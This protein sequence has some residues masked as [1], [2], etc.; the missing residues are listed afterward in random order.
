[1]HGDN[2]MIECGQGGHLYG[3][4]PYNLCS[5]KELSLRAQ[6]LLAH[7]IMKIGVISGLYP[8]YTRGGAEW[9]AADEAR[10]L[11]D[12][13][14]DVFVITT[15]PWQGW[16]SF[17]PR[18][19]EE[20]GVRVYR[21]FSLNIFSYYRI[22]QHVFL[23]RALWHLRDMFNLSAA[24]VVKKIV[25]AE[26]PD[27]V[28]THNLKG[29][30]FLVPHALHALSVKHIHTLHDVHLV[31]PSGLLTVGGTEGR[32]ARLYTR[33]TRKLFGSPAVVRAPSEWLL[34]FYGDRG[35]FPNSQ[36]QVTRPAE[37][38]A[39]GAAQ[40]HKERGDCLNV[41]FVGQLQ[42]HK[43]ILFLMNVWKELISE[44][45]EK[46]LH[47]AI[48]GDGLLANQMAVQWEGY[49]SVELHG[50]TTRDRLSRLYKQADVVVVPSL[51]YEN[52]PTVIFEAHS[53][54]VPVIATRAGGI[55]EIVNEHDV[56]VEAGDKDGLKAAIEDFL[57]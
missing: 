23:W 12:A 31:V 48:A 21:F 25:Q 54:G 53:Y 11:K 16:G 34:R 17:R 13:G 29:F 9:V 3:K 49:T 20:E 18:M 4:S 30:G 6:F 37:A 51:V 44:H 40:G 24:R 50:Y 2:M 52:A 36:K 35:F 28:I 33:V 22:G 8:P 7:L 5:L 41:L 15:E 27:V 10:S 19:T 57:G 32:L 26:Q 43:G 56:L 42:K 45:G 39:V 47:L 38:H 14:A 1:L 46:R 55:P